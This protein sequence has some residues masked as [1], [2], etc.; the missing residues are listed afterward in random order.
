MKRTERLSN[1]RKAKR[2]KVII[3]SSICVIFALLFGAGVWGYMLFNKVEV[4]PMP[5][6]DKEI[7]ITDE[8]TDKIDKVENSDKITNIALFGV[9][10]RE[11]GERG[12]SDAIMIL[13]IDK[14]RNKLKLTSIMRDSRVSIKGHGEDK[15]N[16]AYAFGGPTLAIRTINETY[17]LNIKDFVMIDYNGLEAVIESLGGITID[18]KDYEVDEINRQIADMRYLDKNMSVKKITK[19]GKQ[20]LDGAQAVAYTRS[21]YGGNGDYERTERQ[22][23]VLSI[24]F[25]KVKSQ[26]ISKYSS[27]VTKFAPYVKTSFNALDMIG[28]GTDVLQSGITN[29][30]QER[31]PLDS[32]S[33]GETIDKVWYLVFDKEATKQQVFDYIFNDVKPKEK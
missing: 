25:D 27:L 4:T 13:T 19:P 26:P 24:L 28:L 8:I 22:R 15:I 7:G 32:Y 5:K 9:D 14:G 18:V 23:L 33:K 6:S 3:I 12:R 31:F 16:H 21:R 20:L 1:K 11:T 10:K 2:K 17:G 29:I 30:E